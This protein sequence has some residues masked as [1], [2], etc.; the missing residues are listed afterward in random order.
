MSVCVWVCG[1]CNVC[2]CVC[3]RVALSCSA[4]STENQ[5]LL[6]WPNKQNF[7]S[8]NYET[9]TN[10]NKKQYEML[11]R[12]EQNGIFAHNFRIECV[13]VG[14]SVFVCLCPTL[15]LSEKM[16]TT[17]DGDWLSVV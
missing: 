14:A 9:M 8:K 15:F 16:A 13:D 3:V 10:N 7:E 12:S 17:G 6:H 4:S 11:L 1:L 2:V 5:T